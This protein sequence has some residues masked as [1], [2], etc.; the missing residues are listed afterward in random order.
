[1]VITVD[2]LERFCYMFPVDCRPFVQASKGYDYL[3]LPWSAQL[4][5]LCSRFEARDKSLHQHIHLTTRSKLQAEIEMSRL[6]RANDA[7][8][9]SVI[10]EPQSTASTAS[11]GG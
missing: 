4:A 10:T 9:K 6:C 3:K 7:D 2:G 1:M 8:I 5:N 11:P